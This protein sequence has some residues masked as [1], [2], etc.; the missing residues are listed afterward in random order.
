MLTWPEIKLF[1]IVS[2]LQL[3]LLALKGTD[4]RS[5]QVRLPAFRVADPFVL[6]LPDAR[7]GLLGGQVGLGAVEVVAEF[8]FRAPA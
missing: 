2:G 4:R 8:K 6:L 1:G 5:V 7:L 3:D